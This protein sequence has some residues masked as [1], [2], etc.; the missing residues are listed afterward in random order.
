MVPY[1]TN[2]GGPL[3]G[4]EVL[5]LQG[6]PVDDLLLT[7]EST[8]QMADLAG[9][10]MTSTIVGTCILSAILLGR[11]HLMAFNQ[12]IPPKADAAAL[13]A[14]KSPNGKGKK[15][16]AAAA[17][18]ASSASPLRSPG[19]GLVTSNGVSTL[20]AKDV[21]SEAGKGGVS[22]KVGKLELAAMVLFA[23]GVL[24]RGAAQMD[25]VLLAAVCTVTVRVVPRRLLPLGVAVVKSGLLHDTAVIVDV[26]LA[27]R[28]RRQVTRERVG[29]LLDRTANL[30]SSYGSIVDSAAAAATEVGGLHIDHLG[31]SRAVSRRTA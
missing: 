10:A 5:S 15:A 4:H 28:C 31:W 16:A 14:A 24:H 2:R 17:A 21:A 18:A 8:D 11:D 6:I 12:P 1:V 23:P 7:R 25:L 3:I 27:R 30:G 29:P 19:G 26:G 20:A 13:H 22:L 9:N